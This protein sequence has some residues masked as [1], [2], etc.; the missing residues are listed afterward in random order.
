MKRITKSIYLDLN[1]KAL[2]MFQRIVLFIFGVVMC[3]TAFAQNDTSY[4]YLRLYFEPANIAYSDYVS[5][6]AEAGNKFATELYDLK[7]VKIKVTED[8]DDPSYI[9]YKDRYKTKYDTLIFKQG[10]NAF[11][12]VTEGFNFL[13]E[14]GWQLHLIEN[15]I[16]TNGST[17]QIYNN[18]VSLPDIVTKP[19]YIFRKRVT[20]FN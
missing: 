10:N 8:W 15:N 9:W 13:S 19:I 11:R 7:K 4:S 20:S 17:G 12:T 18:T 1:F 3:C 2:C 6:K 5:L 14:K 16:Q